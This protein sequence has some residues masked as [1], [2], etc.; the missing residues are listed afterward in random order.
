MTSPAHT[1]TMSEI[2]WDG[3]WKLELNKK[4]KQNKTKQNKTKQQQQK[5]LNKQTN[6]QN[7]FKISII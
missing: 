4:T 5:N 6:K 7:A 2:L 3:K 1:R